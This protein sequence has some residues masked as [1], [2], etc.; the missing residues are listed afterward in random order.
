M[1]STLR[2]FTVLICGA[3]SVVEPSTTRPAAPPESG[4]SMEADKPLIYTEILLIRVGPLADDVEGMAGLELG[5]LRP[6]HGP[7]AEHLLPSSFAQQESHAGP[8]LLFA[9]EELRASRT[10]NVLATPTM[11]V[12]SDQ[13]STW[14]FDPACELGPQNRMGG[15]GSLSMCVARKRD[16]S[17]PYAPLHLAVAARAIE[18]AKALVSLSV[19]SAGARGPTQ[20]MEFE[21]SGGIPNLLWI[22]ES[23]AKASGIEVA[24]ATTSMRGVLVI[25]TASI[26]ESKGPDQIN[27][28]DSGRDRSSSSIRHASLTGSVGRPPAQ[29]SMVVSQSDTSSCRGQRAL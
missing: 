9:L 10:V 6:L 1:R 20:P 23:S 19:I 16:S 17:W 5:A 4:S 14:V 22:P 29:T 7:V 27:L 21:A 3:I 12:T 11:L 24:M 2:L 25:V 8:F 13:Q 18:P 28:S 26:I 15:L